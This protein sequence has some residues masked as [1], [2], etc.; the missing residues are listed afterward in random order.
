[1]PTPPKVISNCVEV[2]LLMNYS[3]N[4]GVNVLHASK[5]AGRVVDQAL[6]N[7]LGAA[8]KSAWTANLGALCNGSVA[9][10]RVG[11]RD[12]TQANQP[13]FLDS[14]SQVAGTAVGDALPPQTALCITLRT[15]LS[16]KSFRGR[17]YVGGFAESENQTTG[18]ANTTTQ[19][20]AVAYITAI[21]A[22][23]SA[24]QLTMS[25]A[26]MPAYAFTD[27]RTWTLNDGTTRVDTLGHGNARNGTQQAVTIIQSRN[28][29]WETQRRRNNGRGSLPTTF[30]SLTEM[31]L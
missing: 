29:A 28:T 15:A 23:M 12:L 13:E 16:G 8:I 7:T 31:H 4:G 20:A 17:V 22:A 30:N 19:T 10:V 9:L 24:S 3:T 26:S 6:A 1:M 5:A 18:N 11:V 14:G 25:V 2:R 27:T 21:Q